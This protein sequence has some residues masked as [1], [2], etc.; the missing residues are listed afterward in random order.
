MFSTLWWLALCFVK[1]SFVVQASSVIADGPLQ[2]TRA[3]FPPSFVVQNTKPSAG[4]INMNEWR[5]ANDRRLVGRRDGHLLLIAV[6]VL[7]YFLISF[8]LLVMPVS[9]RGPPQ[10]PAPR[11]RR[12][13]LDRLRSLIRKRQE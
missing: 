4:D 6:A 2:A 1:L 12:S 10:R 13:Q 8:P 7:F 5:A 3:D 9:L 11:R